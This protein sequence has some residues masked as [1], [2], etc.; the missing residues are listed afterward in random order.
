MQKAPDEGEAQLE[1]E[2]VKEAAYLEKIDQDAYRFTS[3]V[4]PEGYALYPNTTVFGEAF[5]KSRILSKE[6]FLEEP[7]ESATKRDS[8]VQ[9]GVQQRGSLMQGTSNASKQQ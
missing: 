5:K 7:I 2:D 8:T 9:F 6:F 1:E 3:P 4:A